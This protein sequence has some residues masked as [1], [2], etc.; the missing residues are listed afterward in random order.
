MSEFA[1]EEERNGEGQERRADGRNE[2]TP[3][4]NQTEDPVFQGRI[5]TVFALEASESNA[6]GCQR[7]RNSSSER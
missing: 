5:A 1:F 4:G 3:V 2:G 6:R 7:W